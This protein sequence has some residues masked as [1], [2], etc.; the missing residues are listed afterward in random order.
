MT[1][2]RVAAVQASYVLMDQAATLDR[3]A[4]LTAEAAA[5]G[6]QLAAFP[7]VFIPGTPIWIDTRPI[8]DGDEDWFRLLA[9]NAVVV[10]GPATERLGAIARDNGVWLVIGVE[11]REQHGGTIYNTV[12]YFSPDG[13]LVGRHRKLVPTGSERTVW[14]MGDGSTLRVVD[15]PFGR[16]G[17]LICW[18]NYMPLARFH[19]YAQGVDLWIAPTLA[20]GD[21]W[22]ATLQHLA[23]ENRMF[24]VGVNPVLHADQIPAAFPHREQLVPPGYLEE[25]GPWLEE[26]NTVII[27]PDGRILAGPVREKQETLIADLDLGA[28]LTGRRHMDPAGHYNRPDIFR[29]HVD[30]SARPAFVEHSSATEPGISP[31][32]S[33][34]DLPNDAPPPT[35]AT[36]SGSG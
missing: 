25:N 35:K 6:A 19:M 15:T 2:L 28:V 10:P 30:T 14:G 23:R 1:S 32:A 29:L 12:L 27:A 24:V 31:A 4:A 21:G 17:G 11:E 13:A 8:W 18:E 36:A 26:G 16:L 9:E 20:I 34:G 22:V 5:Q 3:V 7:E 33:P